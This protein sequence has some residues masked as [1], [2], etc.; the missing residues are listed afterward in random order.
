MNITPLY[1]LS[2]RL[3]NCMIAGTNLVMED[4][5]LRRAVEDIKPYAK[6]APVF[7]KLAELTG[8][9]LEPDREDREELLLD[10]ITLLDALL[11]TQAMT[12]ADEPALAGGRADGGAGETVKR[13]PQHDGVCAV[14]NIPYSQLNALIEA[15][16]TSGAGHYAYV[17]E[18]HTQHPEIFSDYRVRAAMVQALGAPYAELA[19]SVEQWLKEDGSDVV[20]LLKKDFD[21][22]GKKEMVRRVHVI[23]AVCGAKENDFYVSMLPQAEKE[24]REALILALRHEPSNIDLLLELEQT[25]TRGMKEKVLY[26]LAG[27]DNEAA[28]VPFRKLLKKKPVQAFEALYLSK[29]G[30]ASQLVAECMR[31]KLAQLTK[32]TADEGRFTSFEEDE[33]KY[34]ENLL[35]ALVG[36]SGAQIEDVIMEAAVFAGRWGL[37]VDVADEADNAQR[38]IASATYGR[39]AV[40]GK[41]EKFGNEL[42][43]ILQLMLRVNP[44]E[45]LCCLALKL[46]DMNGENDGRNT[47]FGAAVLA[48]LYGKE[49]CT[50]WISAHSSIARGKYSGMVGQ[51][52]QTLAELKGTKDSGRM[53]QLLQAFAGIKWTSDGWGTYS[54]FFN[55]ITDSSDKY[56]RSIPQRLEDD[57]T[58]LL[59]D[60]GGYFDDIII[61]MACVDNR[62]FSRKA[63]EYLYNRAL[64]YTS[65]ERPVKY[66]TALKNCGCTHCDG[67]IVHYLKIFSLDIWGL[68][69]VVGQLPGSAQDKA[70]EAMRAYELIKSGKIGGGFKSESNERMYLEMVD[71]LRMGKL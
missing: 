12:G 19:D 57:F 49:D 36:K 28:A 5:R 56:V 65:K 53:R 10:A 63:E 70:D 24:V 6:A 48:R 54:V 47:Y 8:Q 55:G 27:N 9:L 17:L 26:M 7:A 18:Q 37:Y 2:S 39:G 66:F 20:W 33:V 44:D 23:E 35:P 31:D 41:G 52:L 3:K 43:R 67:L 62:I 1:E 59:I 51:L 38:S 30:W 21:P 25:E 4:F 16:T 22:K 40:I 58:D 69:Y 60:G 45:G 13:L 42:S 11:C 34:W 15:L 61:G 50:E 64:T 68:R 29:E 71:E 32:R 46:F 14:Q